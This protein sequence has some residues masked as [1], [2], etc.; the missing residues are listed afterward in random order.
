MN[1]I[2]DKHITCAFLYSITK[3]GYP[4]YAGDMI[5]YIEEMYNLGFRSVEIE[6][7]G[8]EGIETLVNTSI[9]QTLSRTINTSVT[10]LLPVLAMFIFG[11]EVISNFAFAFLVGIIVGTYSSIYVAVS[12]VV[13]L[14]LRSSKS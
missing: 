1:R 9:N 10:T 4:P 14:F 2:F 11:G 7:I 12:A 3:Y 13:S 5:K 8:Y 6:G